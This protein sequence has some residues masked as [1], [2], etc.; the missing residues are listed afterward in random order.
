MQ[1]LNQA[2]VKYLNKNQIPYNLFINK[3]NNIA[4]A[5]IKVQTAAFQNNRWYNAYL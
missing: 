3:T 4:L 5:F 1:F 2:L